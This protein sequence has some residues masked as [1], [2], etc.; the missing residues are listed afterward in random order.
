MI[1]K[2]GI[3]NT[4]RCHPDL[5]GTLEIKKRVVPHIDGCRRLHLE[6][7]AKHPKWH[8]PGLVLRESRGKNHVVETPLEP[9]QSDLVRLDSLTTRGDQTDLSSRAQIHEQLGHAR[10]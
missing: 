3:R 9:E 7:L 2:L 4:D 10:E 6:G 1:V 5:A 8:R